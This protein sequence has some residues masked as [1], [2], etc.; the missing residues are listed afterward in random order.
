MVWPGFVMVPS[1]WKGIVVRVPCESWHSTQPKIGSLN[2]TK[3]IYIYAKIYQVAFKNLQE[4]ASS[5]LTD[6]LRLVLPRAQAYFCY[7]LP[8]QSVAFMG[9]GL[10]VYYFRG[11]LTLQAAASTVREPSEGEITQGPPSRDS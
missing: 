4:R 10:S 2:P 9:I 8:F 11:H 3:H 7:S 6:F 1:V 5:E